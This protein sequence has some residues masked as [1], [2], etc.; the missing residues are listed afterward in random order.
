MTIKEKNQ[1]NELVD[2]VKNKW[3]SNSVEALVGMLSTVTTEKQIQVLIDSLTDSK[4]EA[5]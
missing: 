3:G 2:A 1:L 5:Q 4:G